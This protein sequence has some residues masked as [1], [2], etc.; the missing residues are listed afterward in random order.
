MSDSRGPTGQVGDGWRL[1]L[2][3]FTAIPTAPPGQVDSARAGVSLLLAPFDEFVVS[4]KDRTEM[5]DATH[6]GK[7]MTKIISIWKKEII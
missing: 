2:G 3:T 5:I 1:A 4:Y 7:V 6:Y